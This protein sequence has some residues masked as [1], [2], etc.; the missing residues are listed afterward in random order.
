VKVKGLEQH[1]GNSD[2]AIAAAPHQQRSPLALYED[3]ERAEIPELL[4]PD[5]RAYSRNR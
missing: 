1:V 3:L 5:L 4:F 2:S